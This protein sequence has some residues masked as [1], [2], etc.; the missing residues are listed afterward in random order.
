MSQ[1]PILLFSPQRIRLD[2]DFILP[3]QD[4]TLIVGL[5]FRP[6]G[7]RFG[8]LGVRVSLDDDWRGEGYE[9]RSSVRRP[10]SHRLVRA[11]LTGRIVG[12]ELGSGL[13]LIHLND[14]SQL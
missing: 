2:L 11:V 7:V 9:K 12:R 1:P 13:A 8:N 10:V 3:E 6:L 4:L 5:V 14:R